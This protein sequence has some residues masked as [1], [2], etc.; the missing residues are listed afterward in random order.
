MGQLVRI[1][2]EMFFLSQ[3]KILYLKYILCFKEPVKFLISRRNG[4]NR[5][6]FLI[7]YSNIYT[8]PNTY[9]LWTATYSIYSKIY[10]LPNTYILWIAAYSIY[11]YI[12]LFRIHTSYELLRT[13][14]IRTYMLF[15]IHIYYELLRTVFIENID[16]I[17]LQCQDLL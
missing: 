17:F 8:V 12:L 13:I 9:I 2:A 11:S 7:P 5:S 14:I 1:L 15:R 3:M 10:A 6:K 4:I 16:N